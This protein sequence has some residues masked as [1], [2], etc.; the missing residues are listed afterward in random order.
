MTKVVPLLTVRA[1]A[2]QENVYMVL[3]EAGSIVGY[4]S[5]EA[6]QDTSITLENL[7]I[8][9][10]WIG[11]GCGSALLRHALHKAAEQGYTTV[12]LESEPNAVGFYRKM[13]AEQYSQLDSKLVP[14]LILP[15][16]RFDLGAVLPTTPR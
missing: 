13:G 14:G 6:P 10:A 2:I 15:L 3:E 11:K 9:P 16:M 12:V 1:Q 4:Y 7:F 8:E 5:L